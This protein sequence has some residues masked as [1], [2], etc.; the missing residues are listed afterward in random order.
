M[1]KVISNNLD[2]MKDDV[3]WFSNILE[4]V[5][6]TSRRA[7]E[8]LDSL[9]GMWEGSANDMFRSQFLADADNMENLYQFMKKFHESLEIDYRNYKKCEADIENMIQ[10]MQA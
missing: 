8:E 1:G 2:Q 5:H 7:F 3:E 4:K 6:A 9:N 10:K